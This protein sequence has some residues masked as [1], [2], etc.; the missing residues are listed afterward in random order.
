MELILI[1]LKDLVIIKHQRHLKWQKECFI[2]NY[3]RKKLKYKFGR[4]KM[5]LNLF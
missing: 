1:N 3:I 5:F 4:K 2:S